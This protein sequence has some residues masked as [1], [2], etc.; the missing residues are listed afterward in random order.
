MRLSAAEPIFENRYDAGRHLA[1]KLA[2]YASQSVVVLGIPN[3]GVADALPR[4]RALS[5][6]PGGVVVGVSIGKQKETPLEEAAGDY[7]E[8]M[9]A[10]YPFADYLA[11][12]ISSPNTPGLRD[13]QKSGYLQQ[14]L[15]ALMDESR[16]QAARLGS[17]RRPLLV[18]L[19][20]VTS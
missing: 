13:L 14:L 16:S 3:G 8:T 15:T 20:L 17:R 12:N 5:P 7:L 9:R 11:V 10:V 6:R 19:A 1:E 18:K 4:L 2:E